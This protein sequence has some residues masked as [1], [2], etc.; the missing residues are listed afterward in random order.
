MDIFFSK[1]HGTGND[2]IV[3]DDRGLTFP[4]HHQSFIKSLCHRQYGVGGD[5]LILLHPSQKGDFSMRI[6]NA[7][8]NEAKMCGNGL[9]CLVHFLKKRRLIHEKVSIET[10]GGIYPCFYDKNGV[11][12]EMGVPQKIEKTSPL[13]IHGVS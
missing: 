8:G 7:D 6:F 9:R 11:S 4:L 2:F 12:V 5:G 10:Q 3:I 1:Y 13:L